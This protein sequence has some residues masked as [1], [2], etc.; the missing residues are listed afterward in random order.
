MPDYAQD[1]AKGLKRYA[2]AVPEEPRDQFLALY[3]AALW[4]A[5]ADEGA[6]VVSEAMKTGWSA[7]A[8]Y[9]DLFAAALYEVGEWWAE[10][11]CRV[12]DEHGAR[13]I[14]ERLMASLSASVE[15]HPSKGRGIV[16]AC[17]EDERHEL[18]AR[19]VAD[20]FVWDGWTVRL[21]GG[22]TPAAE[23]VVEAR[24]RRAD[25]VGLSATMQPS[26]EAVR[27]QIAALRAA[28]VN[29]VIIGGQAFRSVGPDVV[30]ALGADAKADRALL[31]VELAS[32][33]V[34]RRA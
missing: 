19:M 3:L 12:A 26:W 6:R 2:L 14:T 1:L 7:A 5:D 22:D 30:A 17:V 27:S 4:D 25:A 8:V 31:G 15:R 34:G 24:R 18:G 10:E 9:E 16:I 13:V 23:L 32:R 28:G 33:L 20:M 21:L 29:T 11:S